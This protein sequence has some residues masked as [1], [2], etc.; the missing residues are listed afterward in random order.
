MS[1]RKEVI[2]LVMNRQSEMRKQDAAMMFLISRKIH[3]Q[4]NKILPAM[5]H[6]G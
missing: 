4:G 2:Y 5:A 6:T 3:F 1:E